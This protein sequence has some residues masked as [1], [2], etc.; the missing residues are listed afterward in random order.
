MLLCHHLDFDLGLLLLPVLDWLLGVDWFSKEIDHFRINV[1]QLTI[2]YH[3]VFL[4]FYIQR[5]E[6][7]NVNH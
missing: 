2:G 4:I 5:T 6:S 1:L 3:F 7:Q